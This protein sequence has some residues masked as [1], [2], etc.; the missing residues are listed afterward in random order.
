LAVRSYSLSGHRLKRAEQLHFAQQLLTL[1][2]A[3]LPLLNA[4]ALLGR[5]DTKQR[6]HW[7]QSLHTLLAKGNSFSSC[8]KAIGNQFPSEF[9][10][11]IIVSERSGNLNLALR[12]ISEQ[13]EKQI[14][15][16][17][18]IKQSLSLPLITLTSS[19]LLVG[20]MMLWVIPTFEEVF[21][22]F[23]AELPAP[24]QIL[25]SVSRAIKN[26]F[27]IF[28]MLIIL[29][30]LCFW[31]AWDS[32]NTLQKYCDRLAF[33]VPVI[34]DLF[35]IAV[36]GN[37]CRSLGHLIQSG[38]PLLD[39]LRTTAQSSNHWVCHD[40]SAELFKHLARGWSLGDALRKTDPQHLLFD[41]ETLELL[42]IGSEA[43]SLALMLQKRSTALSTRLSNQ[44]NSLSQNL[45]PG[46]II[47]V[48]AM[49]GSLVITLY[50]P[51]FNLGRIV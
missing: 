34:G 8:L 23:Q 10:N 20:V 17:Q 37:W 45:E 38:L 6:N 24:T 42:Q 25:I 9:I 29:L 11:L 28:L 43:G 44:L 14:E 39:A 33:K 50:L 30:I 18:K 2:E 22:H 36:L 16:H 32:L 48:G 49:I 46:L 1:L 31:C 35:R 19:L 12:L 40:Y 51:I 21:S 41:I 13:L 26:Y 4:I 7:L 47:L 5:S 3:G 15:L 27:L